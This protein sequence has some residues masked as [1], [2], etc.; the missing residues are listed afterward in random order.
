MEAKVVGVTDGASDWVPTPTATRHIQLVDARANDRR[1]EL[2][3]VMRTLLTTQ[4]VRLRDAT[5]FLQVRPALSSR[6]VRQVHAH[7]PTA[8]GRVT[9]PTNLNLT[10]HTV[11]QT[12]LVSMLT[13]QKQPNCRFS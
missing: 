13:A 2:E 3:S 12:E 6:S 5:L 8:G 4:G 9:V 10:F 7:P 11:V 1:M